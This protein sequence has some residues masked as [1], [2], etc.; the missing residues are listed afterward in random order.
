[1]KTGKENIDD[2]IA[3]YLCG[4]ALP[5]EA[6]WL[7]DWM[8][9]SEENKLYFINSKKTFDLVYTGKSLTEPGTNQIF[10]NILDQIALPEKKQASTFRLSNYF[11]PLRI[12]ATLLLV[13]LISL[14]AINY[15]RRAVDPDELIASAEAPL[16]KQFADGSS[17]ILYEHAKLTIV[18]GFNK[19][20]RRL[21]LEGMAIFNVKHDAVKPFVIEAG[22]IEISDIG[23]QFVVSAEPA[24]D[25]V[26]VIVMEGAVE[27]KTPNQKLTVSENQIATFIRSTNNLTV[28]MAP[29]K[30]AK[31]STSRVFSFESTELIDVVAQLNDSYGTEIE[32]E[33]KAAEKC[34]I[35]VDFT[36]ESIE[37]ILTVITETLGLNYVKSNSGYLI[38]GNACN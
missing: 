21:K 28:K 27:L 8:L 19:K 36:N 30:E 34:K 6:I 3:K 18:G 17:A 26:N 23:T 4:E 25:S 35:T 7:D 1:M 13:A 29:T 11:T 12:A 14:L 31:T 10:Q 38:K 2:L 9:E 5:E 33:N 24:N 37:T 16:E 22:G 15:S 20:E 32:I